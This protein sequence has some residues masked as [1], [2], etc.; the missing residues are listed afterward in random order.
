MPL[1]RM[2]ILSL[3]DSVANKIYWLCIAEVLAGDVFMSQTVSELFPNRE[4]S[5][6]KLPVVEIYL[7]LLLI[8]LRF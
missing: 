4:I 2:G 8:S 3:E 1:K 7:I 5:I 6:Y